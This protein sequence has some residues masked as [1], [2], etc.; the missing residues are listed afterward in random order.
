[1]VFTDRK[2]ERH[3][4]KG[5]TGNVEELTIADLRRAS[6]SSAYSPKVYVL[7]KDRSRSE[8]EGIYRAERLSAVRNGQINGVPDGSMI[9]EAYRED[10]RGERENAQSQE[11][12]ERREERESIR[13]G[14]MQYIRSLLR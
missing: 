12:G 14:L 2:T 1:M 6:E 7:L 8:I 5:V 11:Q 10:I 3:K 13:G 4:R 9:I